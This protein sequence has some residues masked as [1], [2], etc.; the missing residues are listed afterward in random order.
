MKLFTLKLS[1]MGKLA[2]TCGLTLFCVSKSLAQT[3]LIN[4]PG[5]ESGSSQNISGPQSG[6]TTSNVYAGNYA[7]RLA[8]KGGSGGRF[9]VT[10]SNLLPSSTYDFSAFVQTSGG[11]DGFIGATDFGGSQVEM[12]FGNTAY[13]SKSITFT[14]GPASTS[15]KVYV[16]NPKQGTSYVYLD[17]LSLIET[18]NQYNLIFSEEFNVDGPVD[19]T[20]WHF[21]TGFQR[22]NEEQYYQPDNLI[23]K[24]GNLVISA[25]R[26][27]VLNEFYD[28]NSGDWRYNTE[29][30]YWTS[31]SMV[32]WKG[33]EFLYGRVECRAKVT[34]LTGTWPAIWTVGG[35]STGC[36]EWPAGGEVD[37]M[38]NY[39]NKILA[40]FAVAGAGRWNA[41][42]DGASIPVGDLGANFADEYHIWTLDWTP[43]NMS[44]YIDGIFINSFDPNTPNSNSAYACPG[45]APFTSVPQ[46]LWLNLAMGSN[47]GSTSALPDSTV[48]LV[49]YIRVYQLDEYPVEPTSYNLENRNSGKYVDVDGGFTNDGANII[50]W[51]PNGGQNQQ[52]QLDEVESGYYNL[53]ASHSEKCM[54]IANSGTS[55]GDNVE[56][57]TCNDTFLQQQFS[58]IDLGNTYYQIQN[59][60]S[61][62]CLAIENG[63]TLDGA[64]LVQM[65][66]NSSLNDQQ[67]ALLELSSARS[68]GG[69]IQSG[70]TGEDQQKLL[71]FPNPTRNYL[72]VVLDASEPVQY[73]IHS[74]N[75]QLILTGELDKT[76]KLDISQL[77]RGVYLFKVSSHSYSETR[78][79]VIE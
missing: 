74:I 20:I 68:I 38:E 15:A 76:T 63:S 29:T 75:G 17:E 19:S 58:L 12:S 62:K 33:F 53:I 34:N 14:T 25:V 67:F 43:D 72:N 47:S 70:L 64:S 32:S 48:Y 46:H 52:W 13:E 28:P 36:G 73:S 5:F 71:L 69:S 49:D 21:E 27:T 7:A 61:G 51:T 6:L 2:L 66:C 65:T 26:D 77:E 78:K 24:D 35:N 39:Q 9:E 22:N 4:D 45:V 18:M 79:L 11:G 10:V 16:Y 31:G 3:N 23:K 42:W 41:T 1:L 59:R 60:N 55:D 44:I 56:Q 40:N 37:I 8:N 57:L 50:Q 30:A 54:T